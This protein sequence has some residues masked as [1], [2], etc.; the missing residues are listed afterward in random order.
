MLTGPTTSTLI[1]L[2]SGYYIEPTRV[3]EAGKQSSSAPERLRERE[4]ESQKPS[5]AN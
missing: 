1:K 4:R 5:L 3:E 2:T